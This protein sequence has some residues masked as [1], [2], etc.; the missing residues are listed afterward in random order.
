MQ[1]PLRLIALSALS[2]VATA[3]PLAKRA[4]LPGID[5]SNLQG[6]I[7]WSTLKS[8]SFAYIKATEGTAFIDTYFPAN[9]A[10]AA[11]ASLVRGAYHYAHPNLTTGAAQAQYFLNNGGKWTNDGITLPGAIDLEGDCYGLNASA[12]TAWITD[13]SD[14]YHSATTR[15]NWWMQCTNNTDMFGS[16]N[17]LWLAS[18]A[19]TTGP[20]PAGWSSTTFWQYA[21]SGSYPGDQDYFNGD[22]TQ[23]KTYVLVLVSRRETFLRRAPA[24]D[25]HRCTSLAQG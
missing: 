1:L 10:G 16:T 3:S 20:L 4:D 23:L 14:T 22:A 21:D 5:V 24:S 25:C 8:L 13:F 15:T 9:F 11:N 17:P 18:W 19:S 7:N 6:T 2:A 12:M